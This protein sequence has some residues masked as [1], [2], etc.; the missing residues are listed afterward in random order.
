MARLKDGTPLG[1]DRRLELAA[2]L[3]PNTPGREVL[4]VHALCL[5]YGFS[6]RLYEQPELLVGIRKAAHGLVPRHEEPA[7]PSLALLAR[8][9]GRSLLGSLEPALYV[10][11]PIAVTALFAL[12]CAAVLAN[13]PVRGL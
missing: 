3:P 2:E 13:I 6:G 4:A 1:L 12:Y 5:L 7:Q 8:E 9:T 11:V 10:L